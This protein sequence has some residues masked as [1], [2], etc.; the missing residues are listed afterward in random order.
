[1]P[2]NASSYRFRRASG[3]CQ[4]LAASPHGNSSEGHNAARSSSDSNHP[5]CHPVTSKSHPESIASWEAARA[6]MSLTATP[7]AMAR[8][9]ATAI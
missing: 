1:M 5:I 6:A 7:E 8:I 9:D 3:D 2:F 4:S